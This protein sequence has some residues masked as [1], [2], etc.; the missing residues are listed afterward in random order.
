L[1][2]FAGWFATW[3]GYRNHSIKTTLGNIADGKA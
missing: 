1:Q 3:E 2:A